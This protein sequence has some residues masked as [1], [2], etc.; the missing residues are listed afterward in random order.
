MEH[1]SPE[2]DLQNMISWILKVANTMQWREPVLSTNS[3]GT[4]GYS[5]AKKKK[6]RKESFPISHNVI[7]K[8]VQ[9]GSTG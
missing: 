3:A 8:F 5:H 9:N 2:I 4:I 1:N 7:S 6:K